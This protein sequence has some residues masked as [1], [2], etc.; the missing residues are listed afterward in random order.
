MFE[1]AQAK[2]RQREEGGNLIS[3]FAINKLT[4]EQMM[5]EKGLVWR[6]TGGMNLKQGPIHVVD[7]GVLVW[8]SMLRVEEQEGFER[9]N[10]PGKVCSESVWM[11]LGKHRQGATHVSMGMIAKEHRD[12]RRLDKI[13]H[14]K[15]GGE[16]F[17]ANRL[18]LMARQFLDENIEAAESNFAFEGTLVKAGYATNSSSRVQAD[19]IERIFGKLAPSALGTF[20][21]RAIDAF[22]VSLSCLKLYQLASKGT[23]TSS[24]NG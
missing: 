16:Q 18:E 9:G 19:Y 5:L 15:Q 14:I 21:G 4:I 8:L 6:A 12:L 20:E 3:I 7:G 17:M 13:Y 11:K 1:H 10:E 24:G 2:V 23:A 22:E